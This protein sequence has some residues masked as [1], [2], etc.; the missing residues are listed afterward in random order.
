[1][2]IVITAGGGGHF[3]AAYAVIKI[4]PKDVDFLLIGRKYTFEGDQALSLEYKTAEIEQWN[5]QA[6]T[7]GRVQRSLTIHTIPSIL[8]IPYGYAQ[9]LLILGKYKPDCILSFGG[10]V[11][12]PVTLAAKT[13]GIPVV[14]HEQTLEAG[15]A[16]KLAS[17]FAKTICISWKESEEFF[18]KGKTVLTGNPLK[19]FS[20]SNF[21][22]QIS[23]E[24][25][26]L[27]Y[28][29]GGSGG[30]HFIN[31]LIVSGLERLL[32][33]FRIIHQTGDSHQYN[34]YDRLQKVVD[35]LSPKLAKRYVA[36]K[37]ISPGQ[38]GS[39]FHQ[40]DIVLG[41]AGINT[42]TEV[43][44]FGKPAL[45]IPL[46]Y[47][48]RGEQ[49]KNAQMVA[50]LGFARVVLQ[51]DASVDRV[52]ELLKNMYNRKEEY[53]KAAQKGKQLLHPAAALKIFEQVQKVV[54]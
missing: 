29:T 48:Q 27:L 46:P 42:V 1:M 35:G 10:Y 13:L 34:D 33:T 2:K 11:A 3:A 52:Y 22:F 9:A 20:I 37:F 8:K 28:V 30:A 40:A 24:K 41:R 7:T 49:L 6:L 45:F 23:E 36:T 15:A 16:N 5:F 4:L 19:K 26:P 51:D 38:I 21:Q 14:I 18:P 17:R 12:V 44:Y 32:Q 54:H 31:M 50:S 25:V 39:V 43:L 53:E 47:G